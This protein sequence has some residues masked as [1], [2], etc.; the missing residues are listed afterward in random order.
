MSNPVMVGFVRGK[1]EPY[2]TGG[3]FDVYVNWDW[4]D[5]SLPHELYIFEGDILVYKYWFKTGY[6][7][8]FLGSQEIEDLADKAIKMLPPVLRKFSAGRPGGLLG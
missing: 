2:L 1:A 4:T 7:R 3:R 5:P 8:A 6:A